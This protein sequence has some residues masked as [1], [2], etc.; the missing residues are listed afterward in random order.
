M[1]LEVGQVVKSMAG[2][3]KGELMT[4]LGF[5]GQR[6]LLC[7]VKH[8]KTENP[9]CKNVKHIQPQTQVL[10]V[11]LMTTDRKIRKTL[12]KIANPGG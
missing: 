5:Q 12:N 2:H 7:D 3:D 8:H 11:S 4:V 10:D 1:E 6:V 9:K